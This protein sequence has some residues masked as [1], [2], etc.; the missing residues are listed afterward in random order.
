[1]PQK[2]T[3]AFFGATG[4]S[5]LACLIPALKAGYKCNARTSPLPSHRM[6]PNNMKTNSSPHPHQTPHPP[7]IPQHPHHQPNHNPR[8]RHLPPRRPPN[9]PPLQHF[10]P[11]PVDLII[12]GIGGSLVFNFPNP[13]PTLDN[14]TVCADA[15]RTILA[16]ARTLPS[17]PRIV[18]VSGTGINYTK[19]DVPVLMLPLYHWL[20]GVPHADKR[21]ME[22]LVVGEMEREGERGISGFLFVRPSLLVD[23][24]FGE[25]EGEGGKWL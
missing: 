22:D 18:V 16:A 25:E 13:I 23:G 11:V 10:P 7:A 24:G 5:T 4:G 2:P 6:P 14:P 12:T 3:L 20:L 21:V 8:L 19:R 15:T 1:M 17:K 9:P